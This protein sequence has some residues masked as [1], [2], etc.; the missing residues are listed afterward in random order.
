[1]F[2]IIY[3][4]KR[5]KINYLF[6]LYF[7][8]INL[9]DYMDNF[10]RNNLNSFNRNRDVDQVFNDK[11]NANYKTSENISNKIKDFNKKM[12]NIKDQEEI[13]KEMREANT[14]EAKVDNLNKKMEGLNNNNRS[15]FW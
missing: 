15:K 1:M 8:I 11:W 13:R 7:V 10:N 5:K 6:S 9:G 3:L 4:I 12:F 2:I 14:V